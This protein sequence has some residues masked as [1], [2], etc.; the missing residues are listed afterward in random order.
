MKS[1]FRP[2]VVLFAVLTAVTGLVYPAVMTAFGSV[3][4]VAGG[5]QPDRAKRQDGRLRADR[6]AL[7]CAAI[8]LGPPV[9]HQ[10]DAV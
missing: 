3:P 10:P 9:G 7:R 4:S 8:L 1:M 6:P 5:R 2:L